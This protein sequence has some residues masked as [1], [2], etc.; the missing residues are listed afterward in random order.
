MMIT[1]NQIDSS[2]WIRLENKYKN[3]CVVCNRAIFKGDEILW[4]PQI[5]GQSR[6]LPE[7]CEWLGSRKQ[8]PKR[9]KISK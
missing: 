9:R 7:M 2:N 8:M 1:G 5:S 3:T 6:H 4:N